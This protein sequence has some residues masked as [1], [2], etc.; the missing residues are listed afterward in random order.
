M[1]D[2]KNLSV[3]YGAIDAVKGIS[4]HVDDGEIVSLIGANGAGKTTTLHTITGLVPARSGSIV[5]NGQDLLKTKA[6]K[7]VTL[8]MAH[9]PEGRHVFTRMS[10]QENLEMGAY[11]LKDTSHVA[12]DLDKVYTYFPRLKERR[13]QLAGTLSGGEQQ[14]VAM[15]RAIMSRPNTILMDEPSMGLSPKLVKEI[16]RIIEKL[17]EEGITVLLVE[18]NAKMALSIADRAY[19]LETGRITM[20]G[21]ASDLLHDEKVRKAYLGA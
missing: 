8:G 13:R 3:S 4:L 6:N 2:I 12:E 21:K 17:H 18:Q 7:I 14:M 20:E 19:V 9:V 10:V 5:F 1:L 16:F 15:G 11:S